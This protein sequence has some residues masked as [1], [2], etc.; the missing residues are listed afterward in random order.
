MQASAPAPDPVTAPEWQPRTQAI[1]APRRVSPAGCG[2]GCGCAAV[3]C[4]D[5]AAEGGRREAGEVGAEVTEADGDE[6]LGDEFWGAADYCGYLRAT[7]DPASGR[8]A[9]PR[10]AASNSF[11]EQSRGAHW[12]GCRLGTCR[13]FVY[14]ALFTALYSPLSSVFY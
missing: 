12:F 4:A 9:A 8:C 5:P 2:C 11:W 10:G 3:T 7:F 13:T 6:E 14:R 1:T